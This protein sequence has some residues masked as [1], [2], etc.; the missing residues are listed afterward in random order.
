MLVDDITAL[1]HD[2]FTG[3]YYFPAWDGT[4]PIKIHLG[5]DHML[6]VS[7]PVNTVICVHN[8]G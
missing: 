5:L 3:K 6:S 7:I 2:G 8:G 1:S 4:N